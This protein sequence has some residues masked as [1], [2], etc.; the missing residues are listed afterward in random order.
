MGVSTGGRF[1]CE[2]QEGRREPY[3]VEGA[4]FRVWEKESWRYS[5]LRV[6]LGFRVMGLESSRESILRLIGFILCQAY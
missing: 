2:R 3:R 6:K 1:T 5:G 4:L